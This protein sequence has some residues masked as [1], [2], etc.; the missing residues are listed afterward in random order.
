MCK[1]LSSLLLT[2]E[3]EKNKTQETTFHLSPG[4]ACLQTQQLR[5]SGVQGHTCAHSQAGANLGGAT[6][7]PVSKI[8]KNQRQQ[9]GGQDKSAL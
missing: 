9:P 1:A 5:R 8:L 4:T 2:L 6:A 3:G 7:D